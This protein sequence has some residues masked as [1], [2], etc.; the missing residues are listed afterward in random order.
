MLRK[1]VGIILSCMLFSAA[2]CIC[3]SADTDG[4]MLLSENAEYTWQKNGFKKIDQGM[5]NTDCSCTML[6]DGS[7]QTSVKSDYSTGEGT[8]SVIFKLEEISEIDKIDVYAYCGSN[9]AVNSYDIY[10]GFDGMHFNK[11][12]TYYNDDKTE[13][14]FQKL[15]QSLYPA[16]K[17]KYIKL[18]F[19][20]NEQA[21][22]M[23][24]GEVKIFGKRTERDKLLTGNPI[25]SS[26]D[27]RDTIDT[28]SSYSWVTEQPFVTGDDMIESDKA[29]YLTDSDCRTC[30]YTTEENAACLFDL[31][32]TYQ[33]TDL[34]VFSEIGEGIFTD[35][36]EVRVS[37]DGK[38]YYSLGYF[39][40]KNLRK[41]YGICST[42]LWSS[43]NKVG[44]YVKIIAHNGAEKMGLSQVCIYGCE[45]STD[46]GCYDPVQSV[47]PTIFVKNYFSMFLDWSNYNGEA[48]GVEKY[49]LYVEKK[50]FDNVE[51]LTPKAVYENGSEEVKNQF[52]VYYNL[53]P[54]ST[55]YVAMT[56]F[57]KND[58]EKKQVTCVKIKTLSAL[59]NDT[60]GNIF[61]I[62]DFPYGGGFNIDHGDYEEQFMELRRK[63]LYEIEPLNKNRWWQSDSQAYPHFEAYL[64]MGI[65]FHIKGRFT[66]ELCKLYNE[67]YGMW[68]GASGNEPDLDNITPLA[69][70]N[71]VKNNRR[72]M[73]ITDSRNKLADPVINNVVD[74]RGLKFLKEFY[75]ADQ[76]N[77]EYTRTLF[78]AMDYHSYCGAVYGSYKG[79]KLG[80]PEMIYKQLELLRGTMA[81]Y[82][83]E[84][85]PIIS[86]EGG[87]ATTFGGANIPTDHDLQRDY[88]ARA[89]LIM[90]GEGVYEFYWYSFMDS[91]VDETNFE[92]GLG[93]VDWFGIPKK[94]YYGYYRLAHLLKDCKLTGKI[95]NID[96]PYYGYEYWDE[97]KNTCIESIWNAEGEIATASITTCSK[98]EKTVDVVSSD[99]SFKSIKLT[100]G[101]ANVAISGTPVFIVSKSGVEISSIDK[102]FELSGTNIEMK[103]EE[104]TS[105]HIIRKSKSNDAEGTIR[106]SGAAGINIVS[107]TTIRADMK[108]IPLS[109]YADKNAQTGEQDVNIEIVNGNEVISSMKLTVMVIPPIRIE[110]VPEPRVQ[111]SL[112]E[113]DA[114]VY[115]ENTGQ[116]VRSG[117]CTVNGKNDNGTNDIE[118]SDNT[119]MFDNLQPGEKRRY[120]VP[121]VRHSTKTGSVITVSLA[122]DG[123]LTKAECP[124]SFAAA[125]NDGRAPDIDG[126]ISDGEW[127]NCMPILLD[128]KNQVQKISNW[129]G[130]DDLSGTAYAK[131][132][133][134]Y[135]YMA[136]RVR[137][138]IHCQDFKGSDIW[139]GDSVQLAIDGGRENH[140]AS[141]HSFQF[142]FAADGSG[143]VEKW[144]WI[145]PREYQ[146]GGCDFINAAI[147]TEENETVY[148]LAIPWKELLNDNRS[149]EE[150]GYVGISTLIND[151][152]GAER[153]GWMEFMSGLG[154]GQNP[155]KFGELM[156]V[157]Q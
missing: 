27:G 39:V 82:G 61:C 93:I 74:Y 118:L 47:Q 146:K 9:N 137:D 12:A 24:I 32:K 19:N 60:V 108:D 119:V 65:A 3:V 107:D 88:L 105:L 157:K 28:G 148:E 145:A 143:S 77:G 51:K 34:D 59:N 22:Y 26:L 31:G 20:K 98:D 149:A 8:A 76:R 101:R 52:S 79:L 86:S 153:R 14:D 70:W 90:S 150:H 36:Y 43:S 53:E 2:A 154:N 151:N 123:M 144:C 102:S 35:G 112:K 139:R 29:E 17:A 126:V 6:T 116:T 78:D 117:I 48:N 130:I 104:N 5:I 91:G 38:K 45:F 66:Q 147:K 94:S 97:C 156:L 111:G 64:K 16:I 37:T 121:V 62:N 44:R 73:D 63:L 25:D 129:T 83:D 58:T 23:Q 135:L 122:A 128:S 152:D 80:S 131:W 13:G 55:F 30:A 67:K 103:P 114:A 125:L 84:N 85:K 50:P 155:N 100:D 42:K 21:N 138:N 92:H 81:E 33:I 136:Y 46:D 141:G 1:S 134:N 18:V 120:A 115:L 113:W 87:W 95:D 49:A 133:S 142:G 109:L 56:P 72:D 41:N 68:T 4:L 69:Y 127:D 57:D 89:Y 11:A 40:N 15:E 124:F 10:A 96:H 140:S 71:K 75:E 7:L 54:E 132:D 99:G 106:I 110:I